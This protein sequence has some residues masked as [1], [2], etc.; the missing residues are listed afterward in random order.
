MPKNKAYILP[1]QYVLLPRFIT[2]LVLKC[3][4]LKN[5]TPAKKKGMK[6]EKHLTLQWNIKAYAKSFYK[7]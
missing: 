1:I 6:N 3:F 7:V 5:R 4:F 2:N